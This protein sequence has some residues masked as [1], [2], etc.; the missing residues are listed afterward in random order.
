M[1]RKPRLNIIDCPHHITQRGNN[2]QDVFFIDD[3]RQRYLSFLHEQS[4]KYDLQILGYCLMTNHIHLIVIPRN[5]DSLT[6][7]I[8]RT[9]WLYTRSIN[10]YHRRSGHLWQNRFFSCAMG[11]THFI[12][13]MAYIERNPVRAGMV[14]QACD[15]AWSS[16]RD[17]CG[18]KRSELFLNLEYWQEQIKVTDWTEYLQGDDDPHFKKQFRLHTHRGRPLGSDAFISRLETFL[19]K[20]LRPL[21]VGR[22]SK[23]VQNE[24]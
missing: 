23:R 3:D 6:K 11:E 9:H 13:A 5:E 21:P 17:H 19:N 16:A 12:R 14:H 1:A 10:Y 2:R 4:E 22:P 15:Y 24:L 18:H 20:R 8:G 7:A